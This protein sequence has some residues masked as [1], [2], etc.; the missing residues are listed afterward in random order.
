[1]LSNLGIP[2]SKSHLYFSLGIF[3]LLFYFPLNDA[4]NNGING[5]D[6]GTLLIFISGFVFFFFRFGL[7]TIKGMSAIELTPVGIID[8]VRNRTLYW[9][10][11]ER[12]DSGSTNT[13]SVVIVY[14]KDLS[15]Y[16]PSTWIGYI[17]YWLSSITF[18]SPVIIGT[19]FVDIEAPNLILEISGYQERLSE[20]KHS[21]T[22][23]I[24]TPSA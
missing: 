23:A 5:F 11:I 1:M 16:K 9:N 24:P 8:N 14:L 17:P 13:S 10:D 21:K 2:Y 6:I 19:K 7:P 4:Y 18:G 22:N 3:C 12:F 15:K 20:L